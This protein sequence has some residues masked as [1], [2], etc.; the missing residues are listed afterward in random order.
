M[1]C[2][3]AFLKHAHFKNKHP[4]VFLKDRKLRVMGNGIAFR[5]RRLLYRW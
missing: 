2:V 4:M 3:M 5:S 1:A